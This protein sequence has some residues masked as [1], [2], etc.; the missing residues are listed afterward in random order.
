MEKEREAE[1]RQREKDRR[2]RR[3]TADRAITK[4]AR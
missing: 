3:K 1:K 2:E 4:K